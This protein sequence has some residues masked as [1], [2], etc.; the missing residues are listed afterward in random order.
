M[1]KKLFKNK[2]VNN[3]SWIVGAKIFQML[4]SLIVG[5]LTARY[6]GSADYGLV[7]YASSYTAFFTSL[8]TLGINSVIVKEFID[9][10]GKEGEIIGTTLGLRALASILSALSI[11]SISMILD[12]GEP[13]TQWV[14]ALHSLGAV[15]HI[16]EVFNYWYS[17]RLES[18]KT[19]ISALIAYGVM[20]VYK[21]ILL[22]SNAS[23]IY[24]AVANSVDYIAV[25]VLLVGIYVKDKG[26]RL[27]FS[28]GY[29][30][31]LLSK[32]CHYIIPGLMVAIYAQT[33]KIMLKQ[34]IGA[35]EVGYYSV[36][37]SVCTMWCFVLAAIID[38]LNP[39]IMEK[40]RENEKEYK[41]LNRILYAIIF[42][43]SIFV[44]LLFVLFG[45]IAIKILYGEEYMPAVLPLKVI[46]WYTA[47]SYLGVARNS[48]I[49]CENK[50]KYLVYIYLASAVSNVVFNLIFLPIWGAVGA[51]FASVLAQIIT[52]V[53]PLFIKPLR[54]NTVLILEALIFKGLKKE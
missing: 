20:S 4:T 38:S 37:S 47:F 53:I 10:P 32:S 6:L 42:Y 46:T 34:M 19:S 17:S 12:Y 41:R 40:H 45:D 14:V 22:A 1:I 43:V 52:I 11:I 7:N 50:Q 27:S 18:K 25:A 24:F 30:K 23:V 51:A 35:E 39:V 33:D 21:I 15:F 28:L 5:V 9:N 8:C 26:Q 54:P 3:A 48:W 16:F 31:K 13:I 2:V 36:A 44:S 49:V 29:G